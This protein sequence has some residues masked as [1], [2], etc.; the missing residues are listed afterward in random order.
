MS[1]QSQLKPALLFCGIDVSAKTLAVAV[2][3]E[4][5]EG[6]QERQFANSATGHRQMI[7]WLWQRGERVRVS[8][9]ATGIYSLDLALALDAAEGL[10]L[11]VLNPKKVNRFAQTLSRCHA[12]LKCR[13]GLH[14]A[15]FRHINP[16]I[17]P[18]VCT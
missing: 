16:G 15:I 18:P 9:E 7:A 5:A 12:A 13:N 17:S 4:Q 6:F 14:K 2:Q 10:E 1:K 3:P 8:L 11:A